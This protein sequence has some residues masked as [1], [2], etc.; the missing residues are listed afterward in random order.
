MFFSTVYVI[1]N[2]NKFLIS[3]CLL[4]TTCSTSTFTALHR[5]QKEILP[6]EPLDREVYRHRS[7]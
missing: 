7:E 3:N 5:L 1:D 2:V 6:A 4:T